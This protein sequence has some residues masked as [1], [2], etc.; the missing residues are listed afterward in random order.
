MKRFRFRLAKL[1][2]L[3]HR[4]AEE[5]RRLVG[6]ALRALDAAE[7]ELTAARAMRADAERRFAAKL[8]E[9]VILARDIVTHQAHLSMLAT[10]VS[11]LAKRA[12]ELTAAYDRAQADLAEKRRRELLFERARDEKRQSWREEAEKDELAQLD[13]IAAQRFIRRGFEQVD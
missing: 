8:S 5:A 1:L 13:E 10:R 4:R 7:R 2:D 6:A 12:A 9:G 3:A 11:A